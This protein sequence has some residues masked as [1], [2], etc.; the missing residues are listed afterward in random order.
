MSGTRRPPRDFVLV[1]TQRCASWRCARRGGAVPDLLGL[2]RTDRQLRPDQA[3]GERVAPRGSAAAPSPPCARAADTRSRAQR[4]LRAA[5]QGPPKP[6]GPSGR[7]LPAQGRSTHTAPTQRLRCRARLD[8]GRRGHCSR[9]SWHPECRWQSA[10]LQHG[11]VQVEQK[12]R[13]CT[14]IVWRAHLQHAPLGEA[15]GLRAAAAEI[16]STED[17]G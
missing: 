4:G 15:D 14:A 16:R 3:V 1:A 12:P 13:R 8:G 17:P 10:A 2:A 5:T 7:M 11:S 6:A 9:S